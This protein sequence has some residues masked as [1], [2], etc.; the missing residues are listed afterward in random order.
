MAESTVDLDN[1]ISPEYFADPYVLF[2]QIRENDPIHWNAL[3][4]F[5][6]LTRYDDIYSALQDRRFASTVTPRSSLLAS[7]APEDL[8]ALPAVAGYLTMFMQ[9]MDPPLHT[10][11]RGLI[12]RSFTP[13]MVEH[14]RERI[15]SIVTELLD[16]VQAKGEFDLMDDLAFPLPSTVIFELLG[17]PLELRDSVR[18]SSETIA[19]FVSLTTPAP[20]Q[21][22]QMA[23]SLQIVADQLRPIIAQRRTQP[24]NDFLSSLVQVEEHGEYLSEQELIILITMLLFAG[25]ETTTNLLGNGIFALLNHPRQWEL[26]KANPSLVNGAVEEMLRFSSPVTIISRFI[27]EDLTMDGKRIHKGE[28]VR[29]ALG[30]ANRDPK[31]FPD[32]NAFNIT[33]KPERILS[34]GFGI[35]FC[36]G[37]ALARMESQIVLTELIRRMPNLRIANDSYQWR[38]NLA[39]PGLLSLPVKC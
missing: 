16:A 7:L 36:V 26:L 3:F 20:G 8:A 29:L 19:A 4:G 35:H 28:Q 30:A 27:T 25:H 1:M 37:A 39:M 5:W 10:R 33:R 6:I 11:Q 18:R 24:Q 15:E 13:R 14:M 34:F 22:Q 9:G 2:E 38:P 31:H 23:A 17:I 21:L 32:P 12:H